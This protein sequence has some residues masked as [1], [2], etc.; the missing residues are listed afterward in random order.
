MA[1]DNFSRFINT[2]PVIYN[3][4]ETYGRWKQFSFLAKRPSDD[5]ISVYQVTSQFEGRPDLI[6]FT[7]YGNAQLDWVLLAF[8][9][10]FETLGWP[11]TGSL[12]EYPVDSVV[13]SELL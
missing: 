6:A 12:I 1:L 10:V 3:G 9:N 11:R 5:L 4:L 8:N 2:D 13:L 7:L